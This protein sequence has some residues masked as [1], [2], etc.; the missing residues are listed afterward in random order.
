[1]FQ[2]MQ[3]PLMLT[4]SSG[5]LAS[6]SGVVVENTLAANDTYTEFPIPTET[7][8]GYQLFL[9]TS[10][11]STANTSAPMQKGDLDFT[12]TSGKV[13]INFTSAVTAAQAGTK[14]RLRVYK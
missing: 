11:A 13:R 8:Y 1:M 7:T 9:D 5:W 10:T 6:S 3:I 14:A 12:T 2:D 4:A